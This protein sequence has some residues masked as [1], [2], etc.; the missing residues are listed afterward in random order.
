[1][2]GI[3]EYPKRMSSNEM[4][5]MQSACER[6]VG[7][8]LKFLSGHRCAKWIDAQVGADEF[9]SGVLQISEEFGIG[10]RGLR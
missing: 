8:V 9:F 5:S 10:V 1:M 2:L 7:D 3:S 4:A 6:L